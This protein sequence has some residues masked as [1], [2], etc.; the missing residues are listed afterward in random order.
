MNELSS[1]KK[2]KK[3]MLTQFQ[4]ELWNRLTIPLVRLDFQGIAKLRLRIPTNK[5]LFEVY[6]RVI[7]SIDKEKEH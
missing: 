6:H 3:T 2:D 5:N 7:I 1:L 4:A